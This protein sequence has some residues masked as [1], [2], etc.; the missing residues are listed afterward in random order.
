MV[1]PWT[2]WETSV[3][4]DG[5]LVLLLVVVVVDVVVF[6]ARFHHPI[7]AVVQKFEC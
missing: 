7:I 3:T 2:G 6:V 5:S 1:G 4:L